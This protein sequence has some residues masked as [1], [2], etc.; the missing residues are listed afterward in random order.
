MQHTGGLAILSV[1][2]AELYTWAFQ[3]PQPDRLLQLIETEFVPEVTVLD[4]DSG[5]ARRFGELRAALLSAGIV[6]NPVDLMIAAVSLNHDLTLVTH[7]V[8]H[9]AS[10]PGLRIED[11]LAP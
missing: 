11:W 2:L 1:V 10:I 3:R 8:R 7:N 5:S 4:F 9:F 6:V